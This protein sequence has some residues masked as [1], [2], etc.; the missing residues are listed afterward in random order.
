MNSCA[1][2]ERGPGSECRREGR[3]LEIAAL[4][5]V[6]EGVWHIEVAQQDI[7]KFN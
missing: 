2:L 3:R 5:N 1:D 4:S 6:Y 7:R